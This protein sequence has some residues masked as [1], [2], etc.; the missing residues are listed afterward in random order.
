MKKSIGIILEG[1]DMLLYNQRCR[2][3]THYYDYL[4]PMKQTLSNAG[5]GIFSVCHAGQWLT[6]KVFNPDQLAEFS[7]DNG[8]RGDDGTDR[9]VL[10]AAMMAKGLAADYGFSYNNDGLRNDLN[11]L[12]THLLNHQGCALCNLRVGHIVTLV[13]AREVDGEVQVLAI[14]SYSES[15]D[16]RVAPHVREVIKDSKIVA[17][18]FN[19]ANVAVG[20]THQYMAY[21]VSSD[22]VRDFNLLHKIQG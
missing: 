7:M 5:C 16:Q 22:I 11:T 15:A 9:P 1:R 2:D 8:G 21:W 19:E 12:K 13:D 14:D 6:G 10:L 20:E 4:K 18:V 3:W 17:T